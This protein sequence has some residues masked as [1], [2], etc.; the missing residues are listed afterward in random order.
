M[1]NTRQ[2]SASVSCT[3]SGTTYEAYTC[4]PNAT[5]TIPF[6]CLTNTTGTITA[7]IDIY[8]AASASSFH[9]SG[10]KSMSAAETLLIS[11]PTG[12][13]LEAG[14]K[15]RVKCTGA[16]ARADLTLSVIEM[17]KPVG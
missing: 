4:P 7:D 5:A 11:D 13:V 9:I 10:G 16:L 12:F 6:L 14:D 2:R 8:R 17:F 15:V 3:V 1:K